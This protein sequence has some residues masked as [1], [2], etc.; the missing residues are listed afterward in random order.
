MSKLL[1]T[2][3]KL[4]RLLTQAKEMSL[5]FRSCRGALEK[6]ELAFFEAEKNLSLRLQMDLK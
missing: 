2:A 4:L 1:W 3:L 5:A 6:E